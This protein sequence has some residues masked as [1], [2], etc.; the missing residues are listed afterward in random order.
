MFVKRD[1]HTQAHQML[2]MGISLKPLAYVCERHENVMRLGAE[3]GD[4]L[5]GPGFQSLA[6]LGTREDALAFMK[7]EAY[8]VF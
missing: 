4:E 5:P 8:D 3:M 6:V 7:L 1:T 2:L